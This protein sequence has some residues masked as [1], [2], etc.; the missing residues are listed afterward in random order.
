MPI[1]NPHYRLFSKSLSNK[2]VAKDFLNT[3]VSLH[4]LAKF[5]VDTITICKTSFIGPK[6]QERLSDILYS[7]KM[8][9]GSTGYLYFLIEHQSTADTLMPFWVL[10][11]QVAIIMNHHL[12]QHPSNKLPVVFP[13]L[14][15]CGSD[16]PCRVRNMEVDCPYQGRNLGSCPC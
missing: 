4:I 14:Y 10:R 7:A 11:N 5:N 12:E 2:E 15:F 8:L 13:V 1:K 6:L 9:D 3:Y 16:K